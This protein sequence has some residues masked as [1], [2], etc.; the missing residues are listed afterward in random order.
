MSSRDTTVATR[1]ARWVM[2]QRGS[3]IA[4]GV[5]FA[6]IVPRWMGPDEFGRYALVTSIS[7]WFALLSGMGAVSMMTRAVPGFVLRQDLEG[8]RTLVSGLTGLRAGLGLVAAALYLALTM[9][10]LRDIDMIGLL[11][12]AG[13]V[14][15]RTVANVL[16]ASMLGLNQAARWAFGETLRRWLTFVLV[17]AGF[18]AWG[19]RGACLGYFTAHAAAL[20]F[21]AWTARAY[22]DRRAL[23]PKLEFLAPYLRTGASFAAGNILLALS[24]R[25]GETLVHL[26]TG[27][28]AEVGYFGVAYGVYV[29]AGQAL[30][31]FAVSFAPM[32]VG[33]KEQGDVPAI[34][35]WISRFAFRLIAG[36]VG[37][38][39]LM[40]L[41]GRIAVALVLG[42]E[43]TSV[44]A[45]L[46]PLAI[47]MVALTVANISRLR[48]LVADRPGVAA[49]AAGLELAA[50]WGVGAILAP[51]YGSYGA[52]LAVLVGATMNAGFSTWC[53]R[54][55]LS[56]PSVTTSTSE[57]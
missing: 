21:G 55:E 53:L 37:V 18:Y 29:A 54:N 34:R 41:V 14:F 45:S 4:G 42:P 27:S 9:F 17:V 30:W 24:Q 10:W 35:G 43:Y 51:E 8:L 32:L 26:S 28:F 40:V 50:F 56:A 16:L 36:A 11:F 7:M 6:L 5:L 38:A 20:L 52:A 13:A 19:F 22:V 44:S 57:A 12:I 23:V 25:T 39:V 1:N 31:H 48:A 49:I 47:A 46:P 3:Q 33:W 15:S 2:V